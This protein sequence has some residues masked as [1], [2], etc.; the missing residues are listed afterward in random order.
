MMVLVRWDRGTLSPDDKA[1]YQ[2]GL[3]YHGNTANDFMVY[4]SLSPETKNATAAF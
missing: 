1:S 4:G 2:Y 3:A